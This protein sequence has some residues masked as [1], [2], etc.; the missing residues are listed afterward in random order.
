MPKEDIFTTRTG[1][2]SAVL[3]LALALSAGF[4]VLAD[5]GGADCGKMKCKG[6]AS[7]ALC[8]ACC[9]N[10][11]TS[12]ATTCQDWCDK[13]FFPVDPPSQP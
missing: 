9:N 11:C 6:K 10:K 8:Y 1:K 12:C 3:A 5:P 2:T 13:Q 7:L 4:T